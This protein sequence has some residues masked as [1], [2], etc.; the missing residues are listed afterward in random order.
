MAFVHT[1]FWKPGHLELSID[2]AR[3]HERAMTHSVRP[4]A[5]YRKTFVWNGVAVKPQSVP[6]EASCKFRML[7]KPCGVC[8][9]LEGEALMPKRGVRP[10]ETFLPAEIWKA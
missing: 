10:P 2:V 3:E 7:R 4:L 6:V 5:Q 9:V 8:H 1:V